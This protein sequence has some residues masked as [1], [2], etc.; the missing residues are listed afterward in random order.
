MGSKRVFDICAASLG[1]AVTF[2]LL[3]IIGVL[4]K[5][6]SP[7]EI[8]YRGRRVGKYGRPFLLYKFRT[9]IRGA[10]SCGPLITAGDDARI[11][12]IGRLLRRTKLDELPSLWNVIKGDMSLVGPRPENE[13]STVLYTQEQ[14]TILTIRPGITSFASIKYRKEE[15]LLAGAKDLEAI[16]Y[17]IMQD[18]LRLE[19]DYLK[20][21]SLWLDL[22]ILARTF[23]A[24]CR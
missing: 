3:C 8:I 4:V 24:L 21:R 18:K 22:K 16:Y 13:R 5:M 6:S 12:P 15:E 19:L 9:M 11:T 10:D 14:R 23:V 20:T 7:G 2:P 17:D 1:L